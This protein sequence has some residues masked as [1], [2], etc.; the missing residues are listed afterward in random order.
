M[1]RWHHWPKGYEFQ[2][3][4]GD[5]EGQGSL[6]CYNPQSRKELDTNDR[7][8]NNVGL[9]VPVRRWGWSTAE[10]GQNN[11]ARNLKSQ[12]PSRRKKMRYSVSKQQLW[13]LFFR[14]DKICSEVHFAH[15]CFQVT[16][17]TSAE[18]KVVLGLWES[19]CSWQ[20]QRNWLLV[21]DCWLSLFSLSNTFLI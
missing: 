12:R 7:L 19:M 16:R 21:A 3:T 18:F 13:K 8:N 10:F 2:Q 4:L 11:G 6:A 17:F 14:I 5:G 15:S 9:G 20:N 1:V